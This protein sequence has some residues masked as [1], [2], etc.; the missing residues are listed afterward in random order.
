MNMNNILLSLLNA[1]DCYVKKW[2]D[3]DVGFLFD[4]YHNKQVVNKD[5]NF[6]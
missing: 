2:D 6:E 3:T 4:I 1:Y 5:R